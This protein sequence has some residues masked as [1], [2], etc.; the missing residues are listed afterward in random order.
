LRGASENDK[1]KTS[2][3]QCILARSSAQRSERRK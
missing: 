1:G 3:L 2:V